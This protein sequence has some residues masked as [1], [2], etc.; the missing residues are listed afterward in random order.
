MKAGGSSQNEMLFMRGNAMS[1]API[2]IGTNQ[3]P[4]P[5]ISAGMTMKKIM[6]RPCTLSGV[7]RQAD[8]KRVG[9]ELQRV[10]RVVGDVRIG[11]GPVPLVALRFD[12]HEAF[13]SGFRIIFLGEALVFRRLAIREELICLVLNLLQVR[14]NILIVKV[15]EGLAGN[16][17]KDQRRHDRPDDLDQRI[18]AEFAWCR[19]RPRIVAQHH[20]EQQQQNE[21][22]DWN[23]DPQQEVVEVVD[24]LG[25]T[26]R[27]RLHTKRAIARN[28]SKGRSGEQRCAKSGKKVSHEGI[29]VSLESLLL[30]LQYVLAATYLFP[31]SILS[32]PVVA[33]SLWW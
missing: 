33:P 15:R 16:G 7:G 23:N 9:N 18:V 30:Y 10:A 4:K 3:L 14:R 2:M 11:I 1:G 12:I 21:N 13:R 8:L 32:Q 6:I 28:G 20:I 29:L 19:V 5:P 22:R 25:N 24:T 26:R 31:R 27:G 17:H